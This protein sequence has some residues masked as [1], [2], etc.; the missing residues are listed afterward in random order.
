MN[1]QRNPSPLSPTT[2]SVRVTPAAHPP[3]SQHRQRDFGIGYGSSS[4]YASERHYASQFNQ[5]LFR[6][7]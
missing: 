2:A 1:S 7:G 5:R 6:C 3:R 4:G